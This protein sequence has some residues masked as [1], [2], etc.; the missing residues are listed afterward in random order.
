[1]RS[2]WLLLM[3]TLVLLSNSTANYVIYLGDS[4]NE[5]LLARF[6]VV[7]LK[8][9]WN[10]SLVSSLKQRGC[11]VIAYADLSHL[12]LD[13]I[14]QYLKHI[15]RE[16]YDGIL[17]Y[18]DNMR[19]LQ[20]ISIIQELQAEPMLIGVMVRSRDYPPDVIE[21]VI[22]HLD[23]VLI[24]EFGSFYDPSKKGYF[25]FDEDEMN[26]LIRF[27][28]SIKE[29]ALKYNISVLILAYADPRSPQ[30]FHE[31][32]SRVNGLA[33]MYGFISYL[34]N[35]NKTFINL[36]YARKAEGVAT[37]LYLAIVIV[38][39]VLVEIIFKLRIAGLRR[40]RGP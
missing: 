3:V 35:A 5:E 11:K 29:M 34:T 40:S 16:H 21:E 37:T 9:I 30:L 18:D 13:G 15:I 4:W 24:D 38:I 17:I 28:E 33:T 10:M 39:I 12:D 36:Y 14:S 8:P 22:P 20:A 19:Y 32:M 2:A 26:R 6:D 23:F 27:A 7:I 1:M 25:M 31:Y